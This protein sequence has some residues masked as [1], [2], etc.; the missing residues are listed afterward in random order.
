MNYLQYYLRI[1]QKEPAKWD[2]LAQLIPLLRRAGRLGVSL[3][4][5][6]Y[7][8]ARLT[9]PNPSVDSLDAWLGHAMRTHSNRQAAHLLVILSAELGGEFEKEAAHFSEQNGDSRVGSAS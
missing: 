3:A 5:T 2:Q 9:V 7:A 8:V 1:I 4:A 6:L